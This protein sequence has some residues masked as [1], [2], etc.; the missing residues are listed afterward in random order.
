MKKLPRLLPFVLLLIVAMI[1]FSVQADMLQSLGKMPLYFIENRGQM[2]RQVAYYIQGQDKTIYFTPKGV[3]FSL[4]ASGGKGII[5]VSVSSASE[6][7]SRWTIKLDFIGADP[8][9]HPVGFEQNVTTISYFKGRPGNHFSDQKTFSRILYRNLWPGIDLIYYGSVDQLKYEFIVHPGADPGQIRLAYNGADVSLTDAGRLKIRTPIGGFEDGIPVAYQEIDGQRVKIYMAYA[10]EKKNP[11]RAPDEVKREAYGFKIGAYDP[12]YPLV[13]DP[14]VLVYSGFIGG[15]AGESGNG[16]AVDK[17]GNA[18]VTGITRSN[19][20]DFP[21]TVGP[22]LTY[23]QNGDAFVAKVKADGTG[24]EY[25]G[26]IGG[27]NEDTGYGIA[28][29]D[30]GNAYVVGTTISSENEGFPVTVGP[31]LTHNGGEDAFVCKINPAGTALIYCGYLGGQYT[32]AGRGIAVDQNGHAYVTGWTSSTDLEGFPLATGPDMTFNGG[33][34]DIFVAKVKAD[35]TGLV[36]SGYIGGS[37]YD[38]GQGIAVD[39]SG[40]AYVTGYTN[41]SEATFPVKD[42]PDLTFNGLGTNYDAFVAKVKSDGTSLEYCGYVGGAGDDYGYGIAVDVAGNAYLTGHTQSSQADGFPVTVGPDLT[43]NGGS[44]DVFAAKVKADGSGFHYCGYVGGS[45]EDQ[46]RGIAIDQSGNAY[47]TGFTT[48]NQNQG[49]PVTGGPDLTHNNSNDAFVA[50]INMAGTGIDYCGY[51]GGTAIDYGQAIAVD[52]MGNAYVVGYTSSGA[53]FPTVIGPDLTINGDSEAFVSKISV[54]QPQLFL[55]LILKGPIDSPP[56][57]HSVAVNPNSVVQ[58][59]TIDLT[60]QFQFSDPDGDLDGGTFNFIAPGGSTVSMP[61]P[62]GY[63]G[64]TSGLG[65]GYVYDVTVDEPKGTINIPCF[66]VDKKGLQSNFYHV[67]FTV[68]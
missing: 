40:N 22:D 30:A 46:G 38:Y 67:S 36:Y 63:A 23:N 35:G 8:E 26:Y 3:T 42:G 50:R 4:A 12:R 14:V 19:A 47:L 62:S 56:T 45:G 55:P 16:I 10:L 48:S 49:F 53:Q 54:Y 43:Y 39:G 27:W 13:L 25:C 34:N 1:P 20:T 32:E 17:F 66:L 65:Y 24:L 61:I 7:I 52:G 9:V 68:N 18:Y 28:V 41:S 58:G 11:V 5:P 51:I 59:S 31:D 37:G 2:D 33:W 44:Y 15:S 21:A 60:F 29:D 57:L 64:Q 6:A